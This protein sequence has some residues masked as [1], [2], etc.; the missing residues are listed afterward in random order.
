MG[1]RERP[2]SHVENIVV[3]NVDGEGFVECPKRLG[4]LMRRALISDA[5][6]FVGRTLEG[7]AVA[8]FAL[9][10]DDVRFL[11]ST[12]ARPAD[13]LSLSLTIPAI[14]TSVFVIKHFSRSFGTAGGFL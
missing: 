7:P 11:T 5:V 10:S 8:F 6:G 1:F 12:A 13:A 9:F 4:T 3:S 14:N 2:F